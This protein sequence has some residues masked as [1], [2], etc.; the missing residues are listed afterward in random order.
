VLTAVIDNALVEPGRQIE[1]TETR[2]QMLGIDGTVELEW[3][4]AAESSG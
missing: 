1:V 3:R 2:A 4:F